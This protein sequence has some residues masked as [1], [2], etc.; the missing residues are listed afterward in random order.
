MNKRLTALI[1]TCALLL[2]ACTDGG[3]DEARGTTSAATASAETVSE[4]KPEAQ[5][6]PE[7]EPAADTAPQSSPQSTENADTKAT[8]STEASSADIDSIVGE[9]YGPGMDKISAED[10]TDLQM[11]EEEVW[12]NAACDGFVYLAEPT[13]VCFNS[14]DNADKF[15]SV[16]VVFEGTEP[17]KAVYKRYNVGDSICG[18]TITEAESRFLNS[19]YAM[20]QTSHAEQ[21]FSGGYAAFEGFAELTGYL[22]ILTD[23]EYAVGGVDDL[24]FIPDSEGQ[25]LP[26]LNYS[27]ISDDRGV[28]SDSSER[29][30]LLSGFGYQS[31]YPFIHLGNISDYGST[32]FSLIEKNTP[33]KVKVNIDNIIMSSS[34]DWFAT[35]SAHVE[36]ID[37]L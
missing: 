2:T 16:N 3:T 31:E 27:K 24:I 18:L 13:G 29:C 37:V 12:N 22:I 33:T 6:S 19:K 30:Y 17:S 1:L 32:M 14:I 7:T 34:I 36:N 25:T 10:I 26:I 20:T 9:L 21:H 23:D 5:T 28:Y 35:I 15:D 11:L 4:T 8:E